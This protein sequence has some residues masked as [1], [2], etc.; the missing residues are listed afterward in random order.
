MTVAARGLARPPGNAFYQVWLL[1]TGTNAMLP[2]GV[3]PDAGRGQYSLPAAQ[4][5]GYNA[6]DISL[7]PDDNDPAHSADSV[8]RGVIH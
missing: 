7:E 1:N 2:V 6:I 4:A 8:L 5:A 3:L